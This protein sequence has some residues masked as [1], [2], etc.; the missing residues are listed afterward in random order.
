MKAENRQ[1]AIT[2]VM[3]GAIGALS[4]MSLALQRYLYIFDTE[5][6]ETIAIDANAIERL[7]TTNQA[8]L[9]SFNNEVDRESET[10][11]IKYLN[12]LNDTYSSKINQ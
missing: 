2:S 8:L 7:L 5:S 3:F 1:R 12:L 11:H 6:G 9:D 4:T 10:V